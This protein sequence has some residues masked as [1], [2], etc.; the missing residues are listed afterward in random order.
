[1]KGFLFAGIIVMLTVA[2][3]ESLSCVQCNSLTDPC[4]YGN[5][6]ECPANASISC[7]TFLT[8]FSLGENIT[9]YEDKACSADNCS[10]AETFTVHVSANETF[11]FASQCCQGKAC[12][13]TNDTIDPPQEEVSSNTGCSACYGSSETSC[14]ETTRK[15]YK[16]ERCVSLIAEFKNE[17]KLVLKGC[18]NVSN[19]TCEFLAT[20]NRTV[21]GVTFLKF[22]CENSSDASSTPTPTPPSSTSDTGS[23]GFFTPLTL[24]NLL[25][26]RLL[27]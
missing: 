14:N 8:N 25:L 19:S 4:V 13:D 22:K 27:L 9:W 5:A 16:D 7:T 10:V 21:G 26:L 3:V 17:T 6:V 12:N 20:G 11:H 18:S 1:M 24:G 15:C 2:A 23:K